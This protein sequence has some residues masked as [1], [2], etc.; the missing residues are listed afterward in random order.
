VEGEAAFAAIIDS[1]TS[2]PIRTNLTHS[3]DSQ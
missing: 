3:F 1:S 2:S